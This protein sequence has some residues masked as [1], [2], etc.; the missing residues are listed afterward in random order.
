MDCG[1]A[2]TVVA[3]R[4]TKRATVAAVCREVIAFWEMGCTGVSPVCPRRPAYACGFSPGNGLLGIGHG[5]EASRRGPKNTN[6][7]LDC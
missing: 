4:K 6:G 1:D 3:D 5:V 7:S 2:A